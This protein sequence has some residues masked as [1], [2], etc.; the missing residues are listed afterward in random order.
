MTHRVRSPLLLALLAVPIAV[1]LGSAFRNQ[2]TEVRITVDPTRQFQTIHGWETVAQASVN[3]LAK[4]D[5][6]QEVLDELFDKAVEFGL[7]RLRL[8]VP[9]SIEN[10]RDFKAELAA[11]RISR[12]EERCARYSTVNDNDDPFVLDSSRFIWSHLDSQVR[13]VVLPLASRLEARGEKLWVNV[14]YTAF[15]DLLCR[16][17]GYDHDRPEEYAEFALAVYQHLRDTF[18]IVPDSWEIMLEPDNTQ[19]W[20]PERLAEATA[21]ASRRLADAGFTPSFVATGVTSAS[22]ALPYFAPLWART[23]LRPFVR[24]LSYHRYIGATAETIAAIG[25]F[26]RAEGVPTAMLEKLNA[27]ADELYQDLTAGNVSAWQQYALSWPGVDNGDHYFILDPSKPPGERALLSSSGWYLRQYF[28]ALRPGA[29]RI[30]A[31]STDSGFRPVAAVNTGDRTAVVV[32]AMRAGLLTLA[33]LPP[34]TY[35]TSCW[36]DRASWDREPDPCAGTVDVDDRGEAVVMM[37]DAGVVSAVRTEN[38]EP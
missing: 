24:E 27:G 4:Y 16:G 35:V 38:V 29:V 6:R 13:D 28:R 14:Q 11:G 36:T 25:D 3:E 12:E 33:G 31:S 20:T 34:G 37:P 8:G 7:T 10:V 1:M 15:T 32:R 26:S 21:A 2:L 30:G 5:N 17:Y 23:E 22:N 18:G 9:A 19:V